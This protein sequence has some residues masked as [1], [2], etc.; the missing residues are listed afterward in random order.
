MVYDV[1]H[2]DG[3][4]DLHG[5]SNDI[6]AVIAIAWRTINERTLQGILNHISSYVETV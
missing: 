1:I 5:D 6:Y 3:L 4:L 2:E